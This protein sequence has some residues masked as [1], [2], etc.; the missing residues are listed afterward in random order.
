MPRPL[1]LRAAATHAG[2]ASRCCDHRN[3]GRRIVHQ[4]RKNP[5]PA[6]QLIPGAIGRLAGDGQRFA[7]RRAANDLGFEIRG[8]A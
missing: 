8:A 2:L 3:V 7:L 5:R 4:L 1:C 6:L